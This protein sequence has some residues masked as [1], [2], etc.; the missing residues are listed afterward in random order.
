MFD[1]TKCIESLS[2]RLEASRSGPNATHDY[3]GLAL[4]EDEKK[5][6]VQDLGTKSKVMMDG[7]RAA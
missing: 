4:L 6:L 3:E 5:S 7:S 2:D 1:W